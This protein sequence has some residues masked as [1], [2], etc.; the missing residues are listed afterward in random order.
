MSSPDGR[1]NGHLSNSTAKHLLAEELARTRV[2]AS[3]WGWSADR[4]TILGLVLCALVAAADALLGHRVI[5]IGLLIVGPCCGVLTGRWSRTALLGGWAV[6][7]AVVLGVPD[8]IWGTVT[9]YAFLSAVV[10]VAV[11]ST[12][13]SVTIERFTS[14]H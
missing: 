11:V 3:P 10:V 8:D 6:G 7:L 2:E 4:L 13:V 14:R 9:Q 12:V 5:L 1:F